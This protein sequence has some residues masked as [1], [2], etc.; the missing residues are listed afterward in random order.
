[1]IPCHKDN[2]VQNSIKIGQKIIAFLAAL[3]I[4]VSF[5][6]HFII[7]ITQ[8]F[9][10]TL[11]FAQD[12]TARIAEGERLMEM[13]EYVA[14]KQQFELVVS[15]ANGANDDNLASQDPGVIERLQNDLLEARIVTGN[16]DKALESFN[17]TI[18][19]T[20]YRE[21]I[22]RYHLECLLHRHD[23]IIKRFGHNAIEKVVLQARNAFSLLEENKEAFTT[24]DY[25]DLQVLLLNDML[26]GYYLLKDYS[27]IQSTMNDFA[28]ELISVPTPSRSW[29][30]FF[31]L[32]Q[33]RALFNYPE[34]LDAA[35]RIVTIVLKHMSHF[36][37]SFVRYP[38][39]VLLWIAEK[40]GDK[41]E[42]DRIK[43]ELQANSITT[44]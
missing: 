12:F 3:S 35:E 6:K 18:V 21:G 29:P 27:K 28:D 25:N 24:E 44:E 13:A 5:M 9:L 16:F 42:Y 31:W 33:G 11:V 7:L 10:C 15:E 30:E 32:C 4:I 41:E 20:N 14:A 1:M 2:K 37:P 22:R 17:E 36:N 43:I 39:N 26:H 19:F 23:P 34:E 8:V 38:L 40:K